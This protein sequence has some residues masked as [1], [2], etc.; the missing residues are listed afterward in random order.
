[1][2][3]HKDVYTFLGCLSTILLPPKIE[4]IIQ[5]ESFL[6]RPFKLYTKRP[7]ILT[8]KLFGWQF[9]FLVAIVSP[10]DGF[11]CI[12]IHIQFLSNLTVRNALISECDDLPLLLIHL[13]L[14]RLDFLFL[15]FYRGF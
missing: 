4:T 10:A 13:V 8:P 1:M 15:R 5:E 6:F 3:T 12:Q 9:L 2:L 7:T 11:Y 14:F